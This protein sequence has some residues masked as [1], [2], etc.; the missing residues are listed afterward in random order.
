VEF[1]DRGDLKHIVNL[2]K[3]LTVT[4]TKQG[5]YWYASKY[6]AIIISI[7]IR[8]FHTLFV[9]G[10][11]KNK[12]IPELPSSGAYLFRPLFSDALPVSLARSM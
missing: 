9:Q 2:D 5:F 6:Y 1:D 12:D 7:K 3:D 4:F 11:T 10:Y 8:K